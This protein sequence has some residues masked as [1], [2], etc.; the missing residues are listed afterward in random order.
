MRLAFLTTCGF[1]WGGSELL[2]TATARRALAEGHEVLASVFDWPRQHETIHELVRLGAR[3]H[4]RRRF[5]PSLLQRI[6]KK[7]INRIRPSSRQATY[8][9]YLLG[10]RPDHILFNLAG[11]DEIAID[12][13]LMAFVRQ[14]TI[15]F[16]VFYH[17]VTPDYTYPAALAA[18]M[19][20]VFHLSRHSLFTASQQLGFYRLQT[21]D[22]I[23]NA[24]VV[25]HPLR[26]IKPGPYPE[27]D[28]GPV[29]F[30]LIGNIVCRWKGQDIVLDTLSAPLWRDRDWVLDLYGIGEDAAMLAERCERAGLADRVRFPGYQSDVATILA[31]HHA[32]LIPSRQD[33]GP[34]VLFEAMQ[35][36]R[37]VIGTPMG[38][39]PDYLEDG[40]TGFVA[41]SIDVIGFAETLERAWAARERWRDI[42]EAARVQ[43]ALRYD[44]HPEKTLLDLMT[45]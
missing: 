21:A 15:P 5:F 32:V 41:P 36:A 37:P 45:A 28:G 20:S 12:P 29:R 2:W 9:D 26:P 27:L 43:L 25:H 34:I 14:T 44:P 42:G 16:S 1:P 13:D 10:F 3:L 17:N 24:R 39:V 35:A 19:R 31:D 23:V 30:C 33:T 8:H 38:C 6:R 4:L 22:P 18:N 40:I 11:G 7:G